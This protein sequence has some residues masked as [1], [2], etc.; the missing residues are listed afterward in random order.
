MGGLATVLKNAVETA[1]KV[2]ASLQI[3]VT[4]ERFVED[5]KTFTATAGRRLYYGIPTTHQVIV[6]YK[7]KFNSIEGALQGVQISTI[8]FL[9]PLMI[10]TRDRITLPDGSKPQII[11][12]EGVLNPD[13]VYYAPKV[14][15]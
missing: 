12:V 13:G 6:S 3:T 7:T 4:L 15:Y 1:K 5:E 14:I 2:T 8:Q 10:T 11:S 9:E